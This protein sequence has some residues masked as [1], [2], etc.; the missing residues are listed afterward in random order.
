MLSR[1]IRVGA[2]TI[3]GLSIFVAAPMTAGASKPKNQIQPFV[4][5]SPMSQSVYPKAKVVFHAAGST[6]K[7]HWYVSTNGGSSFTPIPG[8]RKS[9]YKIRK[10]TLADNGNVYLV[11]FTNAAGSDTSASA[12]LSVGEPLAPAVATQPSGVQV[13]AGVPATF[14][15]TATGYPVPTVQWYSGPSGS[16]PWSAIPN[17][18]SDA[19]TLPTTQTGESGSAF[20]AVF[21]N[22]NG[23]ITTTPATLA[24]ATPPISAATVTT[25]PAA[26][27]VF[28]GGNA[29][30]VAS[31][32]GNPTPSVQWMVS[33]DDGLTFSPISGATAYQLQLNGV[34]TAASGN[35]Y[36]AVFSNSQG[37]SVTT[38]AAALGVLTDTTEYSLNWAGYIDSNASFT[39]VAAQWT[40]P[41]VTCGSGV[42]AASQWVGIGGTNSDTLE[43][44][45]TQVLCDNGQANYN[46]WF[47]MLGDTSPTVNFGAEVAL[48][49]TNYPVVAGDQFT[50][51]VQYVS[52]VWDFNLTDVT[53][54]WSFAK[55]VPTPTLTPDL[56]SAEFI[57][58]RP[59][60]FSN[61]KFSF[62]TLADIDTVPFNSGTVWTPSTT[63][64]ISIGGPSATVMIGQTGLAICEPSLLSNGGRSFSVYSD[65]TGF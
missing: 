56:T 15:A 38:S 3:V 33:T 30:F 64:S 18:T 20:E 23:T 2:T 54:G 25:Q 63:G 14:T 42:S 22:A 12:T 53:Q 43:Q 49:T 52:G 31:A 36:E 50:S 19:Y 13:N 5:Q 24:V 1:V 44:A 58:E 7:A 37:P 65:P 32:T 29:T 51:N 16:G 59:D 26:T 55:D 61:G 48:S 39:Q 8:A 28:D 6:G 35:Q 62:A 40:V 21:T 47:E 10:A 11:K 57:V 60:L 4:L 9:T 46:A 45:G 41:T 17:A 34:T 27:T